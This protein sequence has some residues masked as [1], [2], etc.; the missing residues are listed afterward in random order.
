LKGLPGVRGKESNM[1]INYQDPRFHLMG[2]WQENSEGELVSYKRIAM[3]A[4]C[5]CGTQITV[6]ARLDGAAQWYMDDVQ[7]EPLAAGDGFQFCTEHGEHRLKVVLV[8]PCRMYLRG[9]QTNGE[10]LT[11][12][13]RPYIHFIGDSITHA[14]PG[15]ASAA[16]EALGVDYSVTA[17]CGM[18]L[19]DGWGWYPL[20]DGLKERVGMQSNYFQLETPDVSGVFTPCRFE[21]SAVPDVIVIYLGV[22]DYLTEGPTFKEDHPDIFA[23]NY[24][25]FVRKLRQLYPDVPVVMLQCHL[26]NRTIRINAIADAYGRI[27]REMD[28]VSLTDTHLWNVAVCADG[29]HPSEAGYNQL[30]TRMA[31]ILK[32]LI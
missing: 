22:N 1:Q 26:P 19:V 10:F 20:I 6:N 23:Q 18:S 15:F 8:S 32:K 16:G 21:Y 3:A 24:T 13:K 29:V 9:A 27:S 14:Y 31:D 17:H 4:I 25:A 12:E 11:P 2:H 7:A 30:A 28:Q 5:F